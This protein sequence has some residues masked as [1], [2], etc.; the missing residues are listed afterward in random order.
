MRMPLKI[1]TITAIGAAL[2]LAA[3]S[4][5]VPPAARS[6]LAQG[7]RVAFGVPSTIGGVGASP[8]LATTSIG[9][10]D[11]R[12]EAP[13]GFTDPVLTIGRFDLGVGTRSLLGQTKEVA[14]FVLEDLVLT[15]EQ[16]GLRTNIVPILEH[17][18]SSMTGSGAAQNGGDQEQAEGGSDPEVAGPRLRIGQ[19]AIKGV[20]AR[21][22]L[23]GVAGLEP[24]D[25]TF[26]V[27]DFSADFSDSNGENG[28]SVPEIAA[29]LVDTLKEKA[30]EAADGEVPAELLT[31]LVAAMEGGLEGG[32]DGALDQIE[33]Q[34]QEG[35]DD[36][37]AL[38]ED[39][40]RKALGGSG[41]EAKSSLE[42][43]LRGLIGGKRDGR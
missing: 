14:H 31:A 10:A 26:T 16:D 7:S 38:L 1:L 36:G 21:L 20:S 39:A 6:A 32:L 4:F 2:L 17:L 42:D 11:Y 23:S 13:E 37:R 22:K 27:P 25:R 24:F 18:G 33:S 34:V 3:G 30:L 43:G 35:L 5:L 9:F 41:D 29:S 8:G 40:A 19:V 28:A 15:L 12:L